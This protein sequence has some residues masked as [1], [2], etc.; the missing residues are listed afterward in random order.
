MTE[1]E[2]KFCDAAEMAIVIEFFFVFFRFVLML[3][4]SSINSAAALYSLGTVI[5][6]ALGSLVL[7]I[8][9]ISIY[10]FLVLES[11]CI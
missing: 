1:P 11:A 7:K 9:R 10:C 2:F 5:C 8:V 6:L 3:L 4:L